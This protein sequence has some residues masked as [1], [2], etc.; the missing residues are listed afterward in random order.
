MDV[1]PEGK[2]DSEDGKLETFGCGLIFGETALEGIDDGVTARDGSDILSFPFISDFFSVGS[3]DAGRLSLSSI[4]GE[5]A[6]LV[7]GIP[8]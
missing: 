2:I 3:T 1:S 6:R 7:L 4:I 8:I 5:Y